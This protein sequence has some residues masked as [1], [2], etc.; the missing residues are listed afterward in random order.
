LAGFPG[1]AGGGGIPRRMSSESAIG[2]GTA[3]RLAHAMRTAIRSLERELIG[4]A[5]PPADEELAGSGWSPDPPGD[6]CLRCGSGRPAAGRSSRGCP[7]CRGRRL[8]FG[9]IVRLGTYREPLDG[10]LLQIK[11]RRWHAMA[12]VL[13][14]L[15]ANQCRAV[16]GPA[17]FDA[18]VP[19][20]MPPLRRIWR[21]IDHSRMLADRV[22]LGFRVPVT[23]L[24][25]HE[26]GRTQVGRSRTERLRRRSPF[27]IDP[28][29]ARRCAGIGR[30]LVVDDVRSTGSTIRQAANLIRFHLPDAEIR[31]AVVAVAERESGNSG[32]IRPLWTE[33]P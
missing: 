17:A 29:A 12:E 1:K 33:G 11:R 26:G 5:L 28:A 4:F 24:L 20:P 19:V 10:W 15:L 16:W 18:V 22:A 31:A 25:G 32:Y 23:E 14:D 27:R 3:R 6:W 8:P 21:G 7:D 30:L 13:G 2:T 9:S